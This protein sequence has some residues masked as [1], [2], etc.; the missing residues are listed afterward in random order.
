MTGL[1]YEQLPRAKRRRLVLRAFL[2][3]L[4]T[5]T[6]LVALY[7]TL[8]LDD[9]SEAWAVT[10]LVLGLVVLA[11]IMAWQV[12]AIVGSEFPRARMIQALFVTVPFYVLTFAAAYVLIAE[13]G[14]ANFGGPLSRTNALYFTVTV[15]STVG[16]GDITAKSEMARLVVTVQ[17]LA[18]LL[19]IGLGARTL[20]GAAQLGLERAE[21]VPRWKQMTRPATRCR[22]GVPAPAS[23]PSRSSSS[24]SRRRAPRSSCRPR[25]GWR[26]ST[27]T[28]RC[29]ARSRCPSSSTSSCAAWP[30]WPTRTPTFGPASPG[31]PPTPATTAGWARSSPATTRATTASCR[32]WRPG[33]WRRSPGSPWTSSRPRPTRSCAAP[34]IPP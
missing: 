27:T 16:F 25:S 34:S 13:S 10:R 9:R 12:R 29:G 11:G 6:V 8:P 26:P 5:T 32:C 23:R 28:A 31:R 19:L 21:G 17:M 18:N 20:L 7:Y 3:A 4:A 24:G 33:S 22:A 2:Q 1:S 14:E 30:P 15:L